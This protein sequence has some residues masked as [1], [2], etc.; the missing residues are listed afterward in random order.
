MPPPFLCEQVLYLSSKG[1][2]EISISLPPSSPLVVQDDTE[3]KY[4]LKLHVDP[5]ILLMVMSSDNMSYDQDKIEYFKS[6]LESNQSSQKA[7]FVDIGA[8]VGLST[9]QLLCTLGDQIEHVYCYEPDPDN[10]RLLSS[11][12]ANFSDSKVTLSNAGLGAGDTTLTLY[13]DRANSGNY[14]LNLS[15]IDPPSQ[16]ND[17]IKDQL[18][19]EIICAEKES[20]KW[21]THGLPIILKCDTQG[22]DETIISSLPTSLWSANVL[23]G[24][25]EISQCKDKNYDLKR[26]ESFL[27]NCHFKSFDLSS[28]TSL[29]T[30]DIIDYSKISG[31]GQNYRDLYFKCL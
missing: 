2:S 9:R 14:S 1:A 29:P 13:R 25:M 27:N 4:P 8:N 22:Y 30:S 11:N 19:V 6:I 15:M 21:T 26:F 10:F 12:L 24:V 31:S 3:N 28:R 7:V 20:Q 18:P 23:G 17:D 5:V 16:E